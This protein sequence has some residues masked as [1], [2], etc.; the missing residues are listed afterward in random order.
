STL[1]TVDIYSKIKPNESQERLVLIGRIATVIVVLLGVAWIPVMDGVSDTLY[2]YLQSVQ[3]YIAPPITAVFLLGLFWKRI[4]AQ[5]AM[6]TLVGGFVLG[7]SRLAAELSKDSLTPGGL[8]HTWADINFLHLCIFLFIIC[9]GIC[10]V[11]SLATQA[12]SEEKLAGLTYG[13]LSP[14]QIADNRNSFSRWDV[15][16]SVGIVVIIVGILS[17]F[18]G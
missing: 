6:A 1:F 8:L 15:V 18:T 10:V 16:A 13:T 5:G 14:D 9:C 2:E 12:P 7:M 4:N 3:S 17:Y 11:V